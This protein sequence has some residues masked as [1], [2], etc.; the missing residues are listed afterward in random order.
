M[1]EVDRLLLLTGREPRAYSSHSFRKG[2]AVS[3][4][5]AQVEDSLIRRA[6]RWRSDAFP[7]L[8]TPS[9]YRSPSV[10]QRTSVAGCRS[11]MRAIGQRTSDS[12]AGC[13]LA[14][15]AVFAT[16]HPHM[17]GGLLAATSGRV[18]RLLMMG[19]IDRFDP[20]GT[21]RAGRG[22]QRQVC[23]R[24][25]WTVSMY[26]CSCTSSAHHCHHC[27]YKSTQ[28][29]TN[30]TVILPHIRHSC[31][32]ASERGSRTHPIVGAEAGRV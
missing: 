2:G 27:Q 17:R 30:S 9:H 19:E 31:T 5:E 22:V 14:M 13:R 29:S 10:G 24:I 1:S 25:C 7:P 12:I 18:E 6:G 28:F 15:H 21:P 23:E 26:S 20:S 8:S 3:M 32:A 4:Q 16:Q 11:A